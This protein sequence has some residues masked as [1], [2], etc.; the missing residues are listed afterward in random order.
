ME[1][2]WSRSRWEVVQGVEERWLTGQSDCRDHEGWGGE[3]PQSKLGQTL[4]MHR[5]GCEGAR[6]QEARPLVC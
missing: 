1:L 2:D 6:V 3:N 4:A 5:A